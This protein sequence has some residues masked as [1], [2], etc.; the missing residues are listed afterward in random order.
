MATY[1]KVKTN[2]HDVDDDESWD[3]FVE[4]AEKLLDALDDLPERAEGFVE[5]VREQLEGMVEWARENEHA[6]E[7]MWKALYNMQDGVGRWQR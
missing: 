4:D 2:I 6:T 3:Q 5:G 7:K 1:K